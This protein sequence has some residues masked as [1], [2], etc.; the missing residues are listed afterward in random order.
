MRA[1]TSQPASIPVLSQLVKTALLN[2][3]I[4]EARLLLEMEND[5]H[6][7]ELDRLR[8]LL[9]P[10]RVTVVPST[11]RVRAEEF[12]WLARHSRQ[13]AGKWVAL[14]GSRLLVEA[15]SLRELLAKLKDFHGAQP[16]IHKL[17]K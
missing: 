17:P 1:Q 3:Q 9:A 5:E 15:D 14:D 4:R 8:L 12:G 2:E 7:K 10:V 13:H 16:L 6:S 11:D